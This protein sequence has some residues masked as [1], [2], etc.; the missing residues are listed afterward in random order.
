ML[1][2]N[3]PATTPVTEGGK[4]PSKHYKQ[5]EELPWMLTGD[6]P[7]ATPTTSGGTRSLLTSHPE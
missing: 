1:T 5:S 4:P 3:P 2:E 6:L 7:V